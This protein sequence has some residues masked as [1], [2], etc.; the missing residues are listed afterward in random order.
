M[1]DLHAINCTNTEKNIHKT[2]QYTCQQC[3]HHLH[4]PVCI[5]DMDNLAIV[6]KKRRY[7]QCGTI[8]ISQ[9]CD[10]NAEKP[11]QC[12]HHF[13]GLVELGTKVVTSK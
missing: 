6:Q 5:T 4:Y 13:V 11:E 3:T 1:T 9:L 10:E 8:K 2:L 7:N 12:G